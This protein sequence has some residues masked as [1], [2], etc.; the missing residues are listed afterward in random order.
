MYIPIYIWYCCGFHY[1]PYLIFQ[2]LL[3]NKFHIMASYKSISQDRSPVP[4]SNFLE[5][6]PHF[7]NPFLRDT[8]VMSH[9]AKTQPVPIKRRF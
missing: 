1:P 4:L 7:Y 5:T 2:A 9:T 3:H 6:L 8:S